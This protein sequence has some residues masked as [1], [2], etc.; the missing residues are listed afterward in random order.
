LQPSTEETLKGVAT[1]GKKRIAVV[2]PSF[3]S[4]CIETLEE[5]AMGGAEVFKAHGGQ[6]LVMIPCLNDDFDWI[7]QFASLI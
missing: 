2:C 7:K 3:V 6:Q 5:I 4:D 1:N